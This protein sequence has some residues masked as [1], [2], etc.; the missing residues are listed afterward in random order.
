[1]RK[2][3][4]RL[5]KED[6]CCLVA[7]SCLTLR[8]HGLWSARLL[9]PWGFSRQE[10]WRGLPCP[11]PGDFPNPGI[12]SRSPAL[13]ADSYYLSQP[14]LPSKEHITKASLWRKETAL[15]LGAKEE[16]HSRPGQ[17]QMFGSGQDKDWIQNTYSH[18]VHAINTFVLLYQFMY[19]KPAVLSS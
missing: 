17:Q 8:L 10:Y 12:A 16:S 1:M 11:P 14:G 19:K 18:Q 7:Q 3:S 13:Q 15:E 5:F 9:C 4:Q 2:S 6:L